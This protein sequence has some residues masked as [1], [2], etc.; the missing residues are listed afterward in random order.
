MLAV[1]G[2]SGEF[3]ASFVSMRLNARLMK[4]DLLKS[5]KSKSPYYDQNNVFRRLSRK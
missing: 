4:T 3:C 5:A 2:V 1:Y